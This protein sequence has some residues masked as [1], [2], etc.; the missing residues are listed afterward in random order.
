MNVTFKNLLKVSAKYLCKVEESVSKKLEHVLNCS[1]FAVGV[2][3]NLCK[4]Q[5]NLTKL[6][7]EYTVDQLQEIFIKIVCCDSG[8]LF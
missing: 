1:G 8:I 5:V 6:N 2:E 7:F 3:I 4:I